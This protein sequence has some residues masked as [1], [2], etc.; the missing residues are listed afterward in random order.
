MASSCTA[1]NFSRIQS[2]TPGR[3]PESTSNPG[4]SV[5]TRK[6]PCSAIVLLVVLWQLRYKLS[7]RDLAEGFLERGFVLTHEAVR[8]WEKRIAP[9]IVEQVWTKRRG[10]AASPWVL[11]TT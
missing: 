8:D 1:F 3:S 4:F 6:I 7:L 2:G 5:G 9:L 10:T 11:H